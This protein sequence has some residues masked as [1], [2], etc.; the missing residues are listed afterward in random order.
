MIGERDGDYGERRGGEQLDLHAGTRR[1]GLGPS[2]GKTWWPMIAPNSIGMHRA[3]HGD[4]A[5]E[6][7]K[8]AEHRVE[9]DRIDRRPT[10][11][12]RPIS[13]ATMNA[14]AAGTPPTSCAGR[15]RRRGRPSLIAIATRPGHAVTGPL[16]HDDGG[17]QAGEDAQTDQDRQPEAVVLVD[18]GRARRRRRA[19][20]A[21]GPRGH[22]RDE[23]GHVG[24]YFLSTAADTTD[25]LTR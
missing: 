13:I 2:N 15:Y 24:R 23:S 16:G 12:I 21:D 5:N 25:G 14:R 1:G 22:G 4:L 8:Y 20:S 10:A 7:R 19:E 18:R 6:E 9:A 3:V 17:E 11:P